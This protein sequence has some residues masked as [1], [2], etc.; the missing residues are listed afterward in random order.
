[1][2]SM[3]THFLILFDKIYMI[4][5]SHLVDHCGGTFVSAKAYPHFIG[6]SVTRGGP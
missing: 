5:L 6:V 4:R 1:M 3:P 2:M